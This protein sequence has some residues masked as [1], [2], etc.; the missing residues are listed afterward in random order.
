MLTGTLGIVVMRGKITRIR[1]R[2]NPCEHV[3]SCVTLDNE[4]VI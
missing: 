2:E 3:F 4:L 1:Y